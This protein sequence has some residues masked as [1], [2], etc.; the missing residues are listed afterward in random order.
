M[1][2]HI[3]YV[4]ILW[5]TQGFPFGMVYF[6]MVLVPHLRERLQEGIP[7]H[8]P[9]SIPALT[10]IKPSFTTTYEHYL[11]LLTMIDN[12]HP[13]IHM[14]LGQNLVALVNIKIA[15]KWVF[16]PL[17][18]RIKGFDIHPYFVPLLRHAPP[19][20][21]P[22]AARRSDSQRTP[23]LCAAWTGARDGCQPAKI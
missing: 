12:H 14:A 8:M 16:T 17:I 2:T 1:Y 5:K 21:D 7:S 20:R 22:H 13:L 15:G 10:V 19:M 23:R 9:S 18:L 4:Y 6:F 3:F 11:P